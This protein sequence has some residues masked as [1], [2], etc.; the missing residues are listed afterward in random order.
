MHTL[1]LMSFCYIAPLSTWLTNISTQCSLSVGLHSAH[2]WTS[3]A[4]V[5]LFFSIFFSLT[6]PSLILPLNEF[7]LS[8]SKGNL[9]T[10]LGFSAPYL[11]LSYIVHLVGTLAPLC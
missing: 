11:I 7:N 4:S 3:Y 10:S 2:V 1:S 6:I 8:S 9:F 5:L